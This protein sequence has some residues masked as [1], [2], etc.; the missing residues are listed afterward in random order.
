M[1]ILHDSI[2]YDK[3]ACTDIGTV[4]AILR[5]FCG[6][7]IEREGLY[8]SLDLRAR[9]YRR[10]DEFVSVHGDSPQP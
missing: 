10:M 8:A 2:R 9:I 5:D 1:C 7:K 3:E 6:S 4:A